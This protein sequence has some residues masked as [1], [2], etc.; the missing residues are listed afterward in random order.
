MPSLPN[1]D[2]RLLVQRCLPEI[3]SQTGQEIQPR[4]FT[5]NANPY[6][7]QAHSK[8]FVTHSFISQPKATQPCRQCQDKNQ[9]RGGHGLSSQVVCFC[10]VRLSTTTTIERQEIRHVTLSTQWTYPLALL[11]TW[12]WKMVNASLL[13]PTG[14]ARGFESL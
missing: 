11:E 5:K 7:P 2:D 10:P 9:C 4:R 12:K 8:L 3:H 14:S 6:V 1:H 13:V